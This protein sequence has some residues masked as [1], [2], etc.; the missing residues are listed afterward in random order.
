M[1]AFVQYSN[2]GILCT[3][4]V[5]WRTLLSSLK[6]LST[7]K[8]LFVTVYTTLVLRLLL[9]NVCSST[10]L[11]WIRNSKCCFRTLQFTLALYMMWV[12]FNGPCRAR[13]LRMSMCISSFDLLMIRKPVSS[14][15]QFTYILWECWLRIWRRISPSLFWKP[16]YNTEV[17]YENTTSY[18]SW[19]T[20]RSFGPQVAGFRYFLFPYITTFS[21][22][23]SPHFQCGTLHS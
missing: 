10:R 11:C 21:T 1:F 2:A 14:M 5:I 19:N 9:C 7:V 12:G 8:P 23:T 17:F 4:S 3:C 13:T 6:Y 20:W 16:S 18:P 15:S 22:T